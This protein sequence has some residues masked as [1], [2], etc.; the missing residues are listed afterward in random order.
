MWRLRRFALK[1][2]A[3]LRP[4]R[5]E[6]ELSSEVAAHL[7][8]L[9]DEF[10]RRGMTAEAARVAARRSFGGV[11]QAKERSREER[12][13]LWLEDARRDLRYTAKMLARAPGFTAVAVLILALGIGA[14][15][16][17]FSLLNGILLR[18]FPL[19]DP[20]RVVTLQEDVGR[21]QQGGFTYPDLPRIRE[22]SSALFGAVSGS[23]SRVVRVRVD[24]DDLFMPLRTVPLVAASPFNYFSDTLTTVEGDLY[25]PSSWITI[26]AR[27]A[28]NVSAAQAETALI[29]IGGR[30]RERDPLTLVPTTTAAL[31]FHSRADTVRFVLLLM[32]VVALVLLVGCANLAGLILARH[33]R[34]RQEVA[35]RVAIGSSRLRLLR[36]FLIDTF[37]L[38]VMGTGSGLLVLFWMVRALRAFVLP[39][40]IALDTLHVGL[41]APV[42]WF[43]GAAACVTVLLCGLVPALRLLTVEGSMLTGTLPRPAARTGRTHNVLLAGQIAMSLLLVIGAALFARSLSAALR[44]DTGLD[45][46]HVTLASV[47][48]VGSGYDEARQAQFYSVLLKLLS[49]VPGVERVTFGD[50]PL[51]SPVSSTPEMIVAGESRRLPENVFILLSGPDY[52]RTLGI[53]VRAGRDISARDGPNSEAVVVIN[54]SLAR[55]LWPGQDAIGQRFTFLPLSGDVR[56]VGVVSDG[57]YGGLREFGRS[58]LYL[59]WEQNRFLGFSSGAVIVRTD[60]NTRSLVPLIQ[61]EIRSFDSELSIVVATLG[62]RI[63]EL[64]MPQRLGTTLLGWFSTL[65]LALAVVGGYGAVPGSCSTTGSRGTRTSRDSSRPETWRP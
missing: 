17:V 18:P 37:L 27:L 35:I 54:E 32:I 43:A 48:F 28:R 53:P 39:G 34:R 65:A 49:P 47:S 51:A 41:T 38:V 33:E 11:E 7:G 13:F 60:R 9:E 63:A 8:V 57:K 19:E 50:V 58:A 61:Q 56:V 55:R 25:S 10:Q 23:G 62:D 31:P 46:E 2:Y 30:G 14:N 45:A 3:L 64:A 20:D 59:P 15:T 1:L 42:L 44:T 40:G 6:Q 5:A 29:T 36:L 24:Q 12:S 22:A 52:F 21:V 4:A 26:T 16:A